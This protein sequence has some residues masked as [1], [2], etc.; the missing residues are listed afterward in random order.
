M[1]RFILATTLCASVVI[2]FRFTN[3]PFGQ[4]SANATPSSQKS[5]AV[6]FTEAFDDPQLLKRQWY[7]GSRFTIS[8]KHPF[9]GNGCLEYAW[10]ADSTNPASSSGVRRLFQ[11]TDTVYLRCYLKLS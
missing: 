11:P 4:T 7:D 1:I 2:N 10:K 3:L 5:S 6:L 8:K 9:A